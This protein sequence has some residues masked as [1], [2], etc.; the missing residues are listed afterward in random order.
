MLHADDVQLEILF[1]D[2]KRQVSKEFSCTAWLLRMLPRCVEDFN[3]VCM[4]CVVYRICI[5]CIY[6]V[7]IVRI[8][9][10]ACV[11]QVF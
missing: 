5:I 6:I 11:T 2:Q 9:C 3:Y 4:Y 7:S 8:V 10:I 1:A